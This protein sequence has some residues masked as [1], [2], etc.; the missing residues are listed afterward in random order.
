MVL[1]LHPA[2]LYLWG[3]QTANTKVMIMIYPTDLSNGPDDNS[4]VDDIQLQLT[5]VPFGDGF[6]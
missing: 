6:Q 5:S 4:P 1:L 3:R 2:L